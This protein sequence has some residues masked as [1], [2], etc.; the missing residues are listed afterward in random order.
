MKFQISKNLLIYSE[1][2]L[3]SLSLLIIPLFESSNLYY[4]NISQ[5]DSQDYPVNQPPIE[6]IDQ[7]EYSND[8]KIKS[9]LIYLTNYKFGYIID[10][11]KLEN[12]EILTVM[13]NQGIIITKFNSNNDNALRLG[14]YLGTPKAIYLNDNV[15]NLYYQPNDLN[16]F[17]WRYLK[18]V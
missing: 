4:S 16:E 2:I 6:W 8:P 18:K 17:F 13:V 3:L 1:L 14:N 10:S 12:N 11:F 5:A 9:S 15:L 7:T